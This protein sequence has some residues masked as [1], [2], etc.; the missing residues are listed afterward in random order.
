MKRKLW[1]MYWVLAVTTV[2]VGIANH[3]ALWPTEGVAIAAAI[4]GWAAFLVES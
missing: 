3:G 2:V 1:I 4:A